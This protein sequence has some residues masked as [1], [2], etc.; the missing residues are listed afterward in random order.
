M[1]IA[2]LIM[3]FPAFLIHASWPG[4]GDVLMRGQAGAR[5]LSVLCSVMLNE[6]S[7]KS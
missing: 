1:E 7:N 4:R 3:A 2:E 5:I 6:K